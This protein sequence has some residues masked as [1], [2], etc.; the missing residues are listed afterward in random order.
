MAEKRVNR[1]KIGKIERS[2][3]KHKKAF[4]CYLKGFFHPSG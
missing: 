2:A 4:Q 3:A 1:A